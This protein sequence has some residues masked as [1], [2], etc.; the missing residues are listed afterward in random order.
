MNT[1]KTSDPVALR[2]LMTDEIYHIT[3]DDVFANVNDNKSQPGL[4]PEP[5]KMDSIEPEAAVSGPKVVAAQ[6]AN[7]ALSIPNEQVDTVS[8]TSYFEYLGENNK[9]ILILVNEAAHQHIAPKE[10]ETLSNILKGKKQELKDVAL[11][12]LNNYPSATFSALKKFFACNSIILFGI[13]AA[14]IGIEPIQLNQ[15]TSFQG[16][17]ILSTFSIAEM[18]T[19]VD[20]KRLFWDKMKS[21]Y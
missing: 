9:Y 3:S 10:L 14:K 18:L 15:I 19:D 6:V 8:A 5:E 7:G 12:N 4:A 21:L 1:L 11:V 17:K 16:T 20:K 2:F 13:D